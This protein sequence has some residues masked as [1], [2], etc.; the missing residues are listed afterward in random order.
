MPFLE[1]VTLRGEHARLEPLS[2][3]Q[4]DGLTE[5]VSDGDLWKLWY[6]AVPT[7]EGMRKEIDRRLGLLAAGAMLPFTVVRRR[8]QDRGH[9]HLHERRCRQPPRRDRLDLVCQACAAQRGQHAVQTAAADACVRE[10][11]LHCGR[12]PHPFLQPP[13]PPRHRTARRQAATASCAAT[14]SRRTA[15]CATPWFTASSPANGRR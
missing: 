10:D 4:C 9:D 1:P 6:T 11:G 13:E 5:A 2:P 15:R 7:P 12:V 14:R 3:D 8:R